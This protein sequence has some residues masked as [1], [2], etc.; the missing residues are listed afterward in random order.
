MCLCYIN[1]MPKANN[2]KTSKLYPLIPNFTQCIFMERPTRISLKIS[3]DITCICLRSFASLSLGGWFIKR[4]WLLSMEEP[5]KYHCLIFHLKTTIS[6]SWRVEVK[7]SAKLLFYYYQLQKTKRR[8]GKSLG[9]F[10][11]FL[12]TDNRELK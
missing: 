12:N 5:K 4:K 11:T 9:T 10:I 2:F 8:K 7:V 6:A 1:A 3:L